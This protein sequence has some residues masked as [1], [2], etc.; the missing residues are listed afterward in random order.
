MLLP[1]KHISFAESLLGLG[2]FV[3]DN[4]KN[5]ITIDN[6]W[7]NFEKVQGVEYPAF[8]SFDNLL[9][10]VDTLYALKAINLNE[11]GELEHTINEERQL[12][13]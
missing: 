3:L 8:H 10:A 2:T 4:V 13:A 5:P 6:L 1:D 11:N 7:R 12:C 9:L